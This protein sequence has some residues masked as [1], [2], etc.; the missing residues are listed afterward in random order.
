M[1]TSYGE[2]SGFSALG[3]E[4]LMLVNGGK[5]GGGSGGG[6]GSTPTKTTTPTNNTNTNVTS[7]L[8]PQVYITDA[9]KA[10]LS[11]P[12]TTTSK[13]NGTA[14]KVVSTVVAVAATFI[15]GVGGII[16]GALLGDAP[17]H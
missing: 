15:P 10:D 14:G 3:A 9:R 7:I 5:G 1:F 4:E 16:A 8:N 6:G 2:T 11:K 17:L 12:N 13:N